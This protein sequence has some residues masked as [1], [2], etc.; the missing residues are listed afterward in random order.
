MK[1]NSRVIGASSIT[2]ISLNS[3]LYLLYFVQYIRILFV[4]ISEPS[5]NFL[6]GFYLGA[7][8]FCSSNCFFKLRHRYRKFAQAIV[9]PLAFVSLKHTIDASHYCY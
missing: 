6:L 2:Y 3:N 5:S 1:E 9:I 8:A 4:C 7:W